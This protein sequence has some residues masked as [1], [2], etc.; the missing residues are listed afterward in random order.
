M[1]KAERSRYGTLPQ[2][3]RSGIEIKARLQ[4]C[5]VYSKQANFA[6]GITNDVLISMSRYL[7]Q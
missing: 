6:E 1:W 2:K 3:L 4:K 5:A 7:S